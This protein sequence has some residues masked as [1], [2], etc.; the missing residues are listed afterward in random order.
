MKRLKHNF[1]KGMAFVLSLAMVAGLVPAM[2]GGADTVQAASGSGTEPS[3]SAYATKEQLMTAFTP[4]SN[5]NATTIGKLVFG[6]NSSED[7]QKWYILGKDSGV[8]GDNTIIFAA[9]PIAT[10][11]KFNSGERDKTYNYGAGTGYGESAGSTDVYAN[12]YG[13]SELR[14]ALQRMLENESGNAVETYFTTAEQGMMNAT[15]VTTKDT[16]NSSVTYTTTDKLYALAADGHGS[17]YK[18]IKAGSSSARFQS[19]SVI[20][21]LR[22]CCD[23]SII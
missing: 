1:K 3:V 2:S 15:T 20:C 6:K 12:H 7:A 18:T 9:S 8:S 22:I 23:S 16:K 13:A 10:R 11:Q 17:S 19:E 21:S 5:G 14:V 4:D